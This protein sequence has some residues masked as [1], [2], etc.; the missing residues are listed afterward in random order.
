MQGTTDTHTFICHT[1]HPSIIHHPSIP[2][3][4]P[5][6]T[7]NTVPGCGK[8]CRYPILVGLF[9]LPTEDVSN[10]DELPRSHLKH[11]VLSTTAS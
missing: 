1:I 5:N 7:T 6:V 9:S 8:L 4:P 11:S 3:S 10:D 2:T